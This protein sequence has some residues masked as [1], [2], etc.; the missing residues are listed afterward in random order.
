MRYNRE[1]ACFAVTPHLKLDIRKCITEILQL[2][3]NTINNQSIRY[4]IA[5]WHILIM[6]F[7][8]L[9]H[10]FYIIEEVN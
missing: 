9:N 2:R 3:R 4:L 10:V 5:F 1:T 8:S 6:F 7:T